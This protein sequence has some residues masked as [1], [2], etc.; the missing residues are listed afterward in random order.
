MPILK[1]YSDEKLNALDANSV[2][3]LKRAISAEAA[4]RGRSMKT[5]DPR[6]LIAVGDSWFSYSLAGLD[7]LDILDGE[8]DYKV[9]KGGTVKAGDTLENMIYGTGITK[10]SSEPKGQ[11]PLEKAIERIRRYKSKI[12]LFSGGGNDIAGIELASYLNHNSSG[13]D[14]VRNDT[15]DYVINEYYYSAYKTMV[16]R[17]LDTND[18]IHIITQNYG[19]PVPDGRG[20]GRLIRFAGPWLKPALSGKRIPEDEHRAITDSLIDRFSDMLFRIKAEFPDRFHVIDLRDKL[21]DD[22]W[23]NELHL[24][25]KAYRRVAALFDQQIQAI[26]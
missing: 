2:K 23:E 6:R 7:I 20:V 19:Y 22:D 1:P 16:Q 14:A 18:D 8:F 9:M 11:A 3:N 15:L 21:D 5:G 13:L 26:I 24:D 10:G 12:F 25:N 4:K 17:V